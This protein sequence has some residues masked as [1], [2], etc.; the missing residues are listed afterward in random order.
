[1]ENHD[2]PRAAAAFDWPVHQAAAV[3]A[4]LTPG[5]RFFHLGQEEGRRVKLSMHVR[6]RPNEPARLETV[7]FYVRLREVLRRFEVRSGQWEL[8]QPRAAWEGNPT[9]EAF[10][11]YLWQ[12]DQRTA[13]LVAVNYGP[14]QGQCYLPLPLG[15]LAGNRVSLKDLFSAATYERSGDDLAGKGLYLDMPPWGYHAFDVQAR[16]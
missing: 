8:L 4:Y 3:A 14:T 6:R 7:E 16:R 13:L 15:N 1:V 2:E 9:A 5:L 12:D 10:L 11:G